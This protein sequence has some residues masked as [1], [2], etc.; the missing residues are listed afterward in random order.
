MRILIVAATEMEVAPILAKLRTDS[1]DAR[2]SEG[3]YREHRVDVLVTGVGMVAT[4]AWCSRAL[5]VTRY[6]LALNCGICGS[7]DP[8]LRPG[9]VAHVVADRIAEL[10]AEDGEAFLSVQELKLLDED[11]FPFTGGQ[12]V[13]TMPPLNAALDELPAVSG[14]T[15]N[16]VHG[17]RASIDAAVARFRPQV[18]SMEGAAF[19]YACLLAGAPFAQIRAVSNVVEPRNRAAWNIAGAIENLG[20]STLNILDH[21]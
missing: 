2:R 16:T 7:F 3:T 12:L 9:R 17:N 8:V 20:Q 10:G 15:V 6:D 14:I 4:A 21:V 13:N 19:M 18:E 5:T 1:E 11:E